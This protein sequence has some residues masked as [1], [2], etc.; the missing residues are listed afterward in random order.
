[1]SFVQICSAVQN[2][3]FTVIEDY[4]SGLK[5]L[6]YMKSRQDLENWYALSWIG[7]HPY[8]S[9]CTAFSNVGLAASVNIK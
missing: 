9:I 8:E 6:L 2:Q 1:M 3:D 5:C 4:I 7:R